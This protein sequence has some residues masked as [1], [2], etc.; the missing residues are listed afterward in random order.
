MDRENSIPRRGY[1]ISGRS[2]LGTLK[3]RLETS[4]PRRRMVSVQLLLHLPCSWVLPSP[5][6]LQSS[7]SEPVFVRSIPAP[8][9]S[10]SPLETSNGIAPGF[11]LSSSP[12]EPP[13]ETRSN[14]T[15]CSG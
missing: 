4:I 13:F 5:P 7:L 9:P 1:E 8:S 3:K 2:P 15:V 12:F 11:A 6:S 14:R 10:A